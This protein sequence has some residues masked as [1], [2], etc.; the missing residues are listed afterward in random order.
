M[1]GHRHDHAHDDHDHSHDGHDD[2]HDH[3]HDHSHDGHDHDHVPK[4][5]ADSEKRV[6]V[7]LVATAT[8]MVVEIATGF[9]ANSLAL[10]SDGFHMLSDSFSLGLALAAFRL[11]RRAPDAKH[12]FGYQRFQVLAAFVNG[13]TLFV[14]AGWILYEA[15][16]RMFSPVEVMAGPMLAVAV[17]GLGINAFSLLILH[18]GDH[19]N[20]NLRGASLHVLGDL[21]GSVAAILAAV[22]IMFTGWTVADP[23]LSVLACVL[24]LRAAW[25]VLRRSTHLLLEGTPEGVVS[26]E[27]R[28]ALEQVD[29]VDE[30]H[31]LHMW[32]LSSQQRMLS[33]HLVVDQSIDRDAVLAEAYALL[34]ERFSIGHATL[35]VEGEH[36]MTSGD[37]HAALG[38]HR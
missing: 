21:L 15:A 8:F 2:G 14:I 28:T 24:I 23:I 25:G 18:R 12:S 13:L 6:L 10:I 5:D 3:D 29:G 20:L 37:C 4:V 27:V 7:V 9:F 17:A 22:I 33:A 36:C 11:G 1:E 16:Q 34:A 30:V 35:Q 26:G 19:G 32:G 31:D 38:G